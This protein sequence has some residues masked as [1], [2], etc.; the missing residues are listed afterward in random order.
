MAECPMDLNMAPE[1]MNFLDKEKGYYTYDNALYSWDMS[2]PDLD[3]SAIMEYII[4]E[5]GP[6]QLL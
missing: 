6:I 4:Q 3:K 1:G 2:I 5:R